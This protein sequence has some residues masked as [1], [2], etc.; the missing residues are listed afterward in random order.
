MKQI[1]YISGVTGGL[2]L[3]LRVVGIFT[4]FPLNNFFLVSGVILLGFVCIPQVL[5]EKSVC[6]KNYCSA[7]APNR[8]RP[9][10]KTTGITSINKK[11]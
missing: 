6:Y 2:F 10:W 1:I 3:I 7:E 8:L 9:R 4:G 5:V 11:R